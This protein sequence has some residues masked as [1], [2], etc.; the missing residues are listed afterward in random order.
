MESTSGSEAAAAPWA[1]GASHVMPA[2]YV[3][4]ADGSKLHLV[5]GHAYN[6][7]GFAWSPDARSILYGRANRQGIYI[8]GADGRNNH[9]LTRDSPR[10]VLSGALAWSPDGHSIA[11]ATDHTGNGD[12]YVINADGHNKIR[13]THSAASDTDPSWQPY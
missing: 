5:T 1:G 10:P 9:R 6:E 11:Y 8:I 7:Y 13:L 4:D 2:I 3:A 12:L